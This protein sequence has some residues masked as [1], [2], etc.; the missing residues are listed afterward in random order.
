MIN[1]KVYEKLK[2]VAKAGTVITY[3]EL[4]SACNLDLDFKNIKDRNIL[5]EIL[6]KISEYEVTY[7]RPMLSALVV[8]KGSIPLS[9]A[10]GFFT[11]ANELKV[12]NEDETNLE[13]YY[14]Q[15]KKCWETWK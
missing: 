2:A 4:N 13:F 10:E 5:S 15:L 12:K 11:W 7:N 9:P 8:Y 14:R 3:S 6:G 1:K